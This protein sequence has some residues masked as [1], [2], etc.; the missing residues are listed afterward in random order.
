MKTAFNVVIVLA[1]L[2]ATATAGSGQC[3]VLPGDANWPRAAAW[4]SL[5]KTLHGRLIAT[6]PIGHVCH[7][8][9][10]DAAACAA[11]QQTWT[12]PVTQYVPFD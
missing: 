7:D 5:N 12:Q 9:T 6:V 10:Y 8:P 11:L 3:R 4:D 1:G 2:A